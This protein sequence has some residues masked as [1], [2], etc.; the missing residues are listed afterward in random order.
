M[1][2]PKNNK[3]YP[4]NARKAYSLGK[5]VG[6]QPDGVAP[7]TVIVVDN[8]ATDIYY[9]AESIYYDAKAKQGRL[10]LSDQDYQALGFI[11]ALQNELDAG[12]A[13]ELPL[14]IRPTPRLIYLTTSDTIIGT[15]VTG[16]AIRE[17]VAI[18]QHSACIIPAKGKGTN[19]LQIGRGILLTPT[20][21]TGRPQLPQNP[22]TSGIP[23]HL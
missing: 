8:G 4:S 23:G 21:Y 22:L 12:K 9:Y 2:V 5:S 10:P 7:L 6:V 14:N 15:N 1:Q 17:G 16:E 3:T 11:D 13:Y 18:F 20:V 19:Y